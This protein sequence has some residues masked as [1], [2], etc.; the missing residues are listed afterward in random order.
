M[1]RSALVRR[2]TVSVCCL[3][4]WSAARVALAVPVVNGNLQIRLDAKTVTEVAG[5]VSVWNDLSPSGLNSFGQA[6]AG[7][8]PVRATGVVN[9]QPAVNFTSDQLN[10]VAGHTLNSGSA[11]PFTFFAVG[12]GATNSVGLFDSAPAQPNVFRF[13][14]TN[15]IELW[16]NNPVLG[17]TPDTSGIVYS[18][19]AS[20]PAN[21]Q[22]EVR[23]F[24]GATAASNSAL[25]VNASP[26]VFWVD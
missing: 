25:G 13:Y 16:S 5:Q 8:Q 15:Q 1:M 26:V 4:A 11:L 20:L 18:V 22:L 14:N 6:A 9:G 19:R 2:L 7:L 10:A 17:V 23:E 21:R 24:R 12:T 3:L